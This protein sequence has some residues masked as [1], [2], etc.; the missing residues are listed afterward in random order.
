M[1]KLFEMPAENSWVK[2][3]RNSKKEYNKEVNVAKMVVDVE[4]VNTNRE[5]GLL[6]EPEAE[7]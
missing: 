1:N 2:G 6:A 4:V 3:L 5:R 7:F